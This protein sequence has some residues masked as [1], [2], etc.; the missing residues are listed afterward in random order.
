MHIIDLSHTIH[1]GM[2]TFPGSEPPKLVPATTYEEHGY[3]ENILTIY[4]HTG[5]HIDAPYHLL[6]NGLTVD[7]F[8]VEHFVGKARV[9]DLSH[10][11]SRVIS[12]HTLQQYEAWLGEI[13]YL[14]LNTGWSNYWGDARYFTDFPALSAEAAEWLL[15]FGLKGIGIDAISIDPI[16]DNALTVHHILFKQNMIIL[17][18]LTNLAALGDRAFLLSCL[19][20]KLQDADG[21]PVR[22]IAMLSE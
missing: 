18:N 10:L 22:A 16:E 19:P 15:P 8:D 11:A 17:E 12:L 21:S 6:P 7:Q 9:I 13:D 14:L 3:V 2:L 4:T 20:L 1:S 5:T